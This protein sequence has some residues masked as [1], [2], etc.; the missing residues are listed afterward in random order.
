MWSDGIQICILPWLVDEWNLL[1]QTFSNFFHFNNSLYHKFNFKWKFPTHWLTW[2]PVL[3]LTIYFHVPYSFQILAP[4]MRQL[5]SLKFPVWFCFF[6]C[7]SELHKYFCHFLLYQM[8]CGPCSKLF[9][10]AF[11]DYPRGSF[12]LVWGPPLMLHL[13]S[14]CLEHRDNV[15][16]PKSLIS[17]SW[18]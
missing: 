13:W 7:Q 2:L 8:S 6:N 3:C 10:E 16:F 5:T 4:T 17:F 15:T 14:L 18:P 9:P 12:C 11:S 1:V